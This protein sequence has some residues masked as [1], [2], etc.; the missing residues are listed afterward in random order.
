M[1]HIPTVLLAPLVALSCV[2]TKP[3][4][5]TPCDDASFF[6]DSEVL[7]VNLTI[8]EDDWAA[9]RAESRS[10]PTEFSGDCRSGPFE[11]SYTYFP[12]SITI[13]GESV[14]RIGARKKGFIGSQSDEKPSLRLNID[15]YYD[16]A[17][18]FCTDNITLNNAVQDPALIRQCLSYSVFRAAGIPAPR[19][20]FATVA[21]NGDPLGVYVNV[22]PIKKKFLRESIGNADGDLYEGTITDFTRS[23]MTTFEPK[24]DDT[25]AELTRVTELADDLAD[26]DQDTET[27]LS[28]HF[29]LDELLTYLAVE[30]WIGHVDGYAGNQNNFYVYRNPE[31]DNMSLV[32]WGVDGTFWTWMNDD[33]EPWF[34]TS[35]FLVQRILA[36]STLSQ[37][38]FDAI[39]SLNGSAWNTERL[40]DDVNRWT[41]LLSA[42]AG[43]SID[44]DALADIRAFIAG[45]AEAVERA[46]AGPEWDEFGNPYCLNRVG[47]ID[48]DFTTN[49]AESP[50][51]DIA[52]LMTGGTTDMRLTWD[53]TEIPFDNDGAFAGPIDEDEE[54]GQV[55]LGGQFEGDNGTALV[56]PLVRFE[57]PALMDE[58]AIEMEW[59]S[60]ALYFVDETT[61]GEPIQIAEFWDGVLQFDE[62]SPI[63]GEPVTGFLSSAVYTW[64][65]FEG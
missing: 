36:D 27:V 52:T 14:G 18:L 41:E 22:E 3:Y 25:D 37:R 56:L 13:D 1:S 16:R 43:A 44:P 63:P 31:T 10:I 55:L 26:E 33:D 47:D 6:D 50:L 62:A 51:D 7:A 30:V 65:E 61:E 15:E 29:D 8:D 54:Y 60:G 9:L 46:M 34:P 49:W 23:W 11:S 21:I 58:L 32:P 45:R 42:D 59:G 5:E 64:E 38:W 24:T 48:A 19:C 4:E 28:R 17:K 57:Q 20:N 12:A 40:L 2:V 53:G 39:R 35:G